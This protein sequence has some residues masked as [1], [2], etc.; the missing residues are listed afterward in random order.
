MPLWLVY[1]L[2]LIVLIAWEF[3]ENIVFFELGWK[4]EN[5][6]DS[7]INITTDIILGALGAA[8]NGYF[9]YKMVELDKNM[10][11]YYIFGIISFIVWILLFV[12]FRQIAY[13]VY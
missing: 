6:L 12:I 11:G 9:A 10:K 1:T 5:R 8:V 13:L 3:I 4:F 2:T 7:P